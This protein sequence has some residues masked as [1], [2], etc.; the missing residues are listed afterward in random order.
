MLFGEC[1][2]LGRG[3]HAWSFC[4]S[5]RSRGWRGGGWR[6]GDWRRRWRG[7]HW[8]R[9]GRRGGGG[10]RRTAARHLDVDEDRAHLH[11][12]GDFVMHLHDLPGVWARELHRRLVAFD[13]AK[14]V[15]LLHHVAFL[16]EQVGELD[17]CDSLANIGELELLDFRPAPSRGGRGG[18]SRRRGR[19]PRSCHGRGTA[20]GR[21]VAENSA[22]LDGRLGLVMQLCHDT[23]VRARKLDGRLV[24]FHRAKVVHLF[25]VVA[26]LNEPLGELH[27]R[28]AFADVRELELMHGNTTASRWR[29]SGSR[30]R[31]GFRRWLRG[32][33]RLCR[34]SHI[35]LDEHGADLDLGILRGVNLHDFAG[36]IARD[37]H[38]GLVAL[39]CADVV[40]RLDHVT[41]LDEEL[42]E[43]NL[44][45]ALA[46][47]REL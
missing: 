6:G 26:F 14:V 37:L 20:L 31:R 13:G 41:L 34:A 46:D 1:S 5:R 7:N 40:A 28:D 19:G 24:T 15:H 17:L 8:S 12:V 11:R 47:F 10:G 25:H 32:G 45:D 22:N 30:C 4:A 35:D 27:L 39:Y 2:D 36:E 43:L 44:A 38:G 9:C 42:G 21:D 16:D 29:R 23:R 3:E 18:G 33:G